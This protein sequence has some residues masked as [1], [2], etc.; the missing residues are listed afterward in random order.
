MQEAAEAG[1][2]AARECAVPLDPRKPCQ[3]LAD[4]HLCLHA[5]ER[6][7]SAGMDAGREGEMPVGLAA[8]VETIR[9]FEL[10]RVA[11]GGADADVHVAAGRNLD[12]AEAGIA[13]CTP[14]AE[15]VRALHPQKFLDRG[16]DAI[17]I[18]LQ[19]AHRIGLRMSRSM[20]L[21]MRLVVVS[22]PALSRKM[23]LCSSSS[24]LSRS[25]CCAAKSLAAIS[26]ERISPSLPSPS[27]N[28]R[29]TRSTR[30]ALNS[31]TAFTPRSNCSLFSTGSSAPRIASDQPR[32]GPRSS[33]GTPSMSPISC[34][35]IAAAKSSIRSK[36]PRSAARP[37][38]RSTSASMRGCK[39]LSARGVNA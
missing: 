25:P 17:R 32:N 2:A 11:V 23:Q 29:R 18:V 13:R 31:A 12:A 6:H 28:R 35:G 27:F 22:W 38:R 36:L 30:Y 10:R 33:D 1:A 3:H 16:V 5:G 19:I 20:L 4:R 34:S 9:I 26:V 39:V 15:L 24:S 37:S 8:D 14:I 21:P 7:A